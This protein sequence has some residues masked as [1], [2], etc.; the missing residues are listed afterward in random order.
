MFAPKPVGETRTGALP[1]LKQSRL[2][3]PRPFIGRRKA[4]KNARGPPRYLGGYEF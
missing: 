3:F 1:A 2:R 4:A